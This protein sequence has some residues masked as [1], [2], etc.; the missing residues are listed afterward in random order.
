[1]SGSPIVVRPAVLNVMRQG[2]LGL[3]A[4]FVFFLALAVRLAY[5]LS[6][7]P[8]LTFDEPIYHDLVVRFSTGKGYSFSSDVF[9]TAVAG[10]PTSF[11]EPVYPLFLS[12]VY[13]PFGLSNH[14]PARVCQA[15]IAALVPVLAV[16]IG[17]RLA[18]RL[19]GLL[20][21]LWLAFQP[22]LIYFSGLLMTETL[23]TT[24]FLLFAYLLVVN[25]GCPSTKLAVLLGVVLAAAAL[26]RSVAAGLLPILLVY[27]WRRSRSASGLAHGLVLAAAFV[28][29]LSPWVARNL[30][31]HGA[32]IPLTTK[33]GT[34]LYFYTYPVRNYDFNNRWEVIT[35]PEMSG[36]NEVQRSSLLFRTGVEH[37]RLHPWLFL[38]FGFH[39]AVDFWNPVPKSGGGLVRIANVVFF[40]GAVVLAW[41]GLGLWLIRRTPRLGLLYVLIGFFMAECMVFTGGMKARLP[42]EPLIVLAG[43]A[44][45]SSW[46]RPRLPG[47]AA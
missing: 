11:Q 1:M 15:F 8:S 18:G 17:D 33:A 21:G 40:G 27:Y 2:G 29:M 30:L 44:P 24:L 20:A 26:T 46:L 19:C 7:P 31:V 12:L 25:D 3:T 41:A 36:L 34:N 10:R 35:F 5:V 16:L 37:I 45:F 4:V 47:W 32:V 13:G 14:L 43:L 28:V 42:V 6:L 9:H 22:S 39:K 23:F 38:E